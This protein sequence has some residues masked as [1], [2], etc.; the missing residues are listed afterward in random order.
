M[1]VAARRRG[2]VM[3]MRPRLPAPASHAILGSWVVLPEPVVP[4]TITTWCR[5][6]NLRISPRITSYNVCYT[7]LLRGAHKT[8]VTCVSCHEAHPPKTEGVIPEC[9]ACHDPKDNS[10]YGIT[11]CVECHDPHA[12][13]ELDFSKIEKAK[14]ACLGCHED[15][16]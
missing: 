12:P 7:K 13:M 14:P 4:Q 2:W 8:E 1:P 15:V 6:I 3:P 9:S 10:H 16:V 5:S 11:G